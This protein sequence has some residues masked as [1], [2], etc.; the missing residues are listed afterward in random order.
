MKK[1]VFVLLIVA[2]VAVLVSCGNT[3]VID[4]KDFE[5][6]TIEVSTQGL[7]GEQ[8]EALT[9]VS[10]GNSDL[11]VLLRAGLFTPQ[12]LAEIG[13]A[14]VGDA[15]ISAQGGRL[16]SNDFSD[17]DIDSLNLEGLTEIQERAIR[18]IVAGDITL[19][20]AVDDGVLTM[21][22][23]QQTGLLGGMQQG[24]QGRSAE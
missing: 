20:K 23:L 24:G 5:G 17:V 22:E 6:N 14:P 13:L 18:D 2:V 21:Q 1:S 10:L 11:R 16:N 12:E 3:E 19:Q 15:N 4:I 9:D 7:S 8:I